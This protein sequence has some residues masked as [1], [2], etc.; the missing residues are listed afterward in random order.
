MRIKKRERRTAVMTISNPLLLFPY[1][2]LITTSPLIFLIAII[3]A[4]VF[5]IS[6]SPPNSATPSNSKTN[7]ISNDKAMLLFQ[8]R[9][10][11][12]EAKVQA[13]GEAKGKPK[14]KTIRMKLID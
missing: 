5:P 12:V 9:G 4:K 8:N 14:L 7:T 10:T 1:R 2:P 13:D 3:T 11:K 6:R